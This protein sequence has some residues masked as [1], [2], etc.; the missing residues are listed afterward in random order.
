[1]QTTLRCM[2]ATLG[3]FA[4]ARQARTFV[5]CSPSRTSS[6]IPSR[7]REARAPRQASA[8]TK[9][10]LPAGTRVRLTVEPATDRVD[11]FGRLLRYVVRV[12]TART[13][14]SAWSRSGPQRRTSTLACEDRLRLNWSASQ[15]ARKRSVSVCGERVRGR[16]TTRTAVSRRAARRFASLDPP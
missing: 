10:L 16:S 14:P 8:T 2:S 7:L 4:V 1:M 6:I 3:R 13:S 12:V 15:R 9:R 11:D 5:A